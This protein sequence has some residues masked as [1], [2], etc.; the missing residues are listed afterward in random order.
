MVSR[1]QTPFSSGGKAFVSARAEACLRRGME[2]VW[3]YKYST[4]NDTLQI[5]TLMSSA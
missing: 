1:L 4:A 5:K 2:A 3:H